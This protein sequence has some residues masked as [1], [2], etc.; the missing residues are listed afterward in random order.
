MQFS[1][2]FVRKAN[3]N[4]TTWRSVISML[5]LTSFIFS[6]ADWRFLTLQSLHLFIRQAFHYFLTSA[7]NPFCSYSKEWKPVK[8]GYPRIPI[9]KYLNF[10]IL[11]Y[12]LE[13][14]IFN[15]LASTLVLSYFNMKYVHILIWTKNQGASALLSFWR[16]KVVLWDAKVQHTTETNQHREPEVNVF[17]PL[18]SYPINSDLGNH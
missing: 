7:T 13:I 16:C 1:L 11:H 4:S 6:L 8:S 18:S 5:S 9:W 17:I 3:A 10:K 15:T 12:F 14:K 2:F